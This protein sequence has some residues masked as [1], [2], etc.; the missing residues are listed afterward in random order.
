MVQPY[1]FVESNYFAYLLVGLKSLL[2][3]CSCKAVIQVT[4]RP[5][6]GESTRGR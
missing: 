6:F 4:L 1:F 2:Y 3:L 5:P